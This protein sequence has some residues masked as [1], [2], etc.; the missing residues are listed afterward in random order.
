MEGN[1]TLRMN[2]SPS[3]HLRSEF[4]LLFGDGGAEVAAFR[5]PVGLYCPKNP[6]KNPTSA[7]KPGQN[8]PVSLI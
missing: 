4:S 5:D 7:Y 2:S 6:E 3:N 1:R 8:R